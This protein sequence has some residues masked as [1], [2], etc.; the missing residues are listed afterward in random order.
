LSSISTNAQNLVNLAITNGDGYIPGPGEIIAI[1][2]VLEET[3][4]NCQNTIIELHI[5]GDEGLTPGYWKNW[6]KH[7]WPSP[8]TKDTLVN[9]VFSN[10][11]Q[12]PEL[13][14]DD[15]LDALQYHGG[16]NDIGAARILLRSAVGAVLNAAHPDIDY[17]LSLSSIIKDVNDALAS[18]DRSIMLD[19]KDIFDDY[20]NLGAEL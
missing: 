4:T 2:A 17:P 11:S 13:D 19:L 7:D 14:G 5:P 1:V 12:Y 15:L 6:E 9:S 16:K 20:N 3:E 18:H 10:S 8:Y